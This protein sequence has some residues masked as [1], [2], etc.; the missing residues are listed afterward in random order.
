MPDAMLIGLSGLQSHQRAIE[1]TSHN[2]ANVSTPGYTRQRA[3]LA[4]NAPENIT[5]GQIGRGVTVEAIKRV[6]NDLI[7]ERIRQS[8]S[9]TTRLSALDQ[10]LT[11]AEQTFN[12]PGETGL[13]A[14]INNLFS[15]FE[16]L[17]NNPESTAL[18]SS[19][20]EQ[21]GTFTSTM[22][23]L[24]DRLQNLRDDLRG[25]LESEVSEVN[26]LTQQIS[27]INQ[28]IRDLSLSGNNPNDLLDRRDALINQLSEHLDLRV[29]HNL[30]DGSVMIDTGGTLLVG[31]DYAEQL[32][33]GSQPD[34]SL[35][36]LAANK[37]GISATG[38]GIGAVLDLHQR[39]IP[40]LIDDID[41][42]STTLA[43]EMNAR[44]S[45]GT[46]HAFR[47][48]AFTSENAIEGSLTATNLDSTLQVKGASGT[49]GL[50]A[51]FLPTFT[52]ANGN[53]IARNLTINVYDSVSKT[54]EK[55]TL[56]YDP[57]T[58]GGVR[59][60]DDIV[61]AINT[62]RST[63]AGG[64]T[65][66]P[67][68]AGG[69]N[70]VTAR[71]VPIDGG[72]RLELSAAT[73]KSIDFSA[74]LDLAPT[75]GAWTSGA[76]TVSGTD[77]SLANQRVVFTVVGNTLQASVQSAVNGSSQAYG[78]SL[79]LGGGAGVIG[80]LALTLTP[81]ASN[82]HNGEQFSVDFDST[83]TAVGGSKTQAQ[84]WTQGDATVKIT[85]RYTGAMNFAPG[86]EWSMRVITSGTIGSATSAPLVEF[87]YF[88]GPADAPVAQS[89]QRVLDDKLQAGSPV[90]IADGVYAV[91]SSG[92]LSTP[93]NEVSFT[94][95][96]EPDQARL[97]PALGI[98]TMFSGDSASTLS[99]SE[100][101]RKDPNRLGIASSRSEGD[102]SNLRN[103]SAIRQERVFDGGSQAIEDFYH[104]SI[105]GLGVR[106]SDT[107]RLKDNQQAL[108]TALENQRQQ[109]SG[110]SLD[111]EVAHLILMQ[112]A[113][114]A[115]ARIITTARE[116]ITTLLE[117]V[118]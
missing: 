113:Y 41:T 64:F 81:V 9:E 110:V 72:Y 34:G 17:S 43:L 105:T 82:Y 13:S 32:S 79:A 93:G 106:V 31:R 117:L 11:A 45:T 88:S 114:T 19:V 62:G 8:Q 97:L 22:N 76:T 85:G 27:G 56:R 59:S 44:Q 116:N 3:D 2:I 25:S 103:M 112:Q 118:R 46:N 107:K 83:G 1:V 78:A 29:R 108:G 49:P 63:P 89:I 80:S 37:V 95:D 58:G 7:I 40:G 4:A 60:L 50:S 61:S 57:A 94:V 35:T 30:S 65:L 16:D 75:T 5:L 87:S 51:A 74:A 10:T 69:I 102:N 36:L 6:A 20:V 73:G 111:E 54:A 77:L 98:N 28:Q 66:Y 52:D 39:I 86:Q 70:N 42:V 26:N 18:R 96:A 12:E 100:E 101:L 33:V 15:S 53:D 38:G 91:F 84:E 14:T 90:Q 21:M 71:K 47:A 67:S 23:G 55:Y 68:N 48:S 92:T 109:T 24:G 115:S 104:T 99:V